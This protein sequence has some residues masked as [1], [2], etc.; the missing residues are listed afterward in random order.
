MSTNSVGMFGRLLLWCLPVV[1]VVGGFFAAIPWLRQQDD[2]FVLVLTAALSI[3]VMGYAQVVSRR[4]QQ[5]LDEVQIAGQGFASSRGW[6]WG[7]MA[8]SLLLLVSPVADRL[9]DLANL[10]STGSADTTDRGAVHVALVFGLM[11]VVFMQLAAVIVASV[12]WQRRM[13]DL[14]GRS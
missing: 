7:A 13:G 1:V 9:I 5:H 8:T 4:L 11:L 14:G 10:L 2:T 6:G 12:I 3:L